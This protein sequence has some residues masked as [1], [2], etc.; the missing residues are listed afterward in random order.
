MPG[1]QSTI[2]SLDFVAAA[3]IAK[4]PAS[5]RSGTTVNDP[6]RSSLTPIIFIVGVPAPDIFAPCLFRYS[7]SAEISGSIAQFLS[8]V[9]AV[10]ENR[11]KDH[12]FRPGYAYGRKEILASLQAFCAQLVYS[13]L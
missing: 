13:V 7:D 4:V 9:N 10:G 1:T 3:I 2:S 11:G 8:T 5:I 6:A 12:A